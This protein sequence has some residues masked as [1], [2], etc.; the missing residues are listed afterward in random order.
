V[1]RGAILFIFLE[2]SVLP[3]LWTRSVLG[4]GGHL[5]RQGADNNNRLRIFQDILGPWS[6]SFVSRLALA[7]QLMKTGF[8]PGGA[9][10]I[11]ISR[12][13]VKVRRRR[14]EIIE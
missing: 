1:T 5:L 13:Q 14:R 6:L 11:K 10:D 2:L 4:R 8:L 9:T 3:L 7:N 12:R